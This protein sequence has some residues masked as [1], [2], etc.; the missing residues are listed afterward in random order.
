MWARAHVCTCAVARVHLHVCVFCFK[1]T[2]LHLMLQDAKDN[3]QSTKGSPA[4]ET[5]LDGEGKEVCTHAML[6][7]QKQAIDE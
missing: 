2:L 7:T 6:W 4:T 5:V 1:Y 3:V